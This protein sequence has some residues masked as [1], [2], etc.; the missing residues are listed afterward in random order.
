MRSSGFTMKRIF[1]LFS[2][3]FLLIL[4]SPILLLVSFTILITLGRPIFFIQERPG[5]NG[6]VF[7]LIKF[8]SMLETRNETGELLDDDQRITP[9]GSILRS[10]SMDE[11]PELFNIFKGEM[12]FV[13]PRPLLIEYMKLY[14]KEQ[15]RRHDVKPGITGWAQ[16]NGRN[17]IS[18]NRKF[19]LD[20]WY[21]D[22]Q[23]FFLDIKILFLTVLKVISRE[24]I[25]QDGSVTSNKFEGNEGFKE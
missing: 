13:G 2:S 10:T 15:N 12:S 17:N 7:K 19:D 6:E 5:E 20:V 11:L 16:I 9:F 22:N 23:T 14:S 24:G 4:L 25:T 3:I 18:W 1:D 21:V 8:R